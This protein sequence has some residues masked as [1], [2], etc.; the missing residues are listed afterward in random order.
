MTA[1]TPT[2]Q[3]EYADRLRADRHAWREL[4]AAVGP[5]RFE[6]PGPMGEW[7]FRDLAGHLLGWRKR[8]IARFEAALRGDPQ[9]PAPWPADLDDDD[10]INDWIRDNDRNRSTQELIDGYDE[11][12]ER[13][14]AGVEALP[15]DRFETPG[16]FPWLD[17][18]AVR[19]VDPT[20][21]FHDEHEATVR[22]WLATHPRG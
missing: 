4:V 6:E 19:D 8:T 9:P 3:T 1:T 5:E 16:A 15:R 10:R 13:L 7:T 18:E 12:F 14:A 21:H 11:S 22:K 20:S 17:G 2:T